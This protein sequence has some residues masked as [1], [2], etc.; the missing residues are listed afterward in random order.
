M[1]WEELMDR[2]STTTT[3]RYDVWNEI[4][5]LENYPISTNGG[6]YF[7]PQED[8]QISTNGGRHFKPQVNNQAPINGE[9][10]FKPQVNSQTP[11]DGG[12]HFKP[13]SNNPLPANGGRHFKP[14][15]TNPNDLTKIAHITKGVQTLTFCDQQTYKYGG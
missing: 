3:T 12:R 13:Q 1:T 8:N 14:Q 6:R 5:K 10:H 4:P 15:D 7:K 9:R 11:T 2:I